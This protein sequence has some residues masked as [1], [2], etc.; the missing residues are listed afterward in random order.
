MVFVLVI[1]IITIITIIQ[2]HLK[3]T[4]QKYYQILKIGFSAK[5]VKFILFLIIDWRLT[6][7]DGWFLYN[8]II[9]II[10]FIIISIIIILYKLR[11]YYWNIITTNNWIIKNTL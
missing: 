6:E 4:Y 8:I 7:G 2:T 5:I 11:F 1:I 3:R 9:I 10:I